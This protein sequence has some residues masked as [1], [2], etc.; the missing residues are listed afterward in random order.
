MHAVEGISN[1]NLKI[2]LT[3]M[4][5]FGVIAGIL[6]A[7]LYYSG[8]RGMS[9]IYVWM[10]ISLLFILIQWYFG[11]NLIK[12]ITKARELAPNE[13]PK[14]HHMVES[15]AHKARIPKPK[16]YVVNNP[17]PNAFAFGRTQSSAGIAVHTG[18]LDTLDEDELEG[19]IAHEIGHIKHRDVII[20]TL[21]SALPVILYYLV[22]IFGSGDNRERG[23]GST[24]MVFV[25]AFIAQFIG[26]LL[27]LWLSRSREY[28]ADA[29]SAYATG[30]PSAL[31]SGLAKITYKMEIAKPQPSSASN[32]MRAFYI[33]DPSGESRGIIRE[34]A[35]AIASG[36]ESHLVEAIEKEKKMGRREW[37]MTHPLTGKRLEALLKI[38]K[39]MAA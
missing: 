10:G 23:I 36:N 37:L 27:V 16:L 2:M 32:A 4:L 34:I 35:S 24:I 14:L 28:Y 33:A 39:Q 13:S 9:G 31:M 18:L 12:W 7:V 19:V 38:K 3:S 17:A 26:Q 21:A 25:G 8:V 5:V 15:L 11:P 20:M 1:L 29:F 22:I 30:K 6:G